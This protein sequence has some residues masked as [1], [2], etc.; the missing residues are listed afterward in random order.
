MSRKSKKVNDL[1]AVLKVMQQ[2]IVKLRELRS[3]HMMDAW[4]FRHRATRPT[5]TARQVVGFRQRMEFAIMSARSANRTLVG[6]L[7]V[8]NLILERAFDA[9]E[10]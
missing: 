6:F 10:I 9:A 1:D 5:N 4:A 7:S 2:V 8:R 3:Q